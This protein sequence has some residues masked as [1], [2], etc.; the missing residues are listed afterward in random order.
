MVLILS[1]GTTEGFIHEILGI[2]LFAI[3]IIHLYLNKTWFKTLNKG[4]YKTRRIVLLIINMLLLL[5]FILQFISGF[6]ISEYLNHFESKYSFL[7]RDLHLIL[8]GWI[9]LFLGI[10]IAMNKNAITRKRLTYF[11]FLPFAIYG[12]Y[13]LIATNT[14]SYM[15][16][17]SR[18]AFINYENKIKTLFNSFSIIIFFTY[19]STLFDTLMKIRREHKYEQGVS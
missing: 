2:V 5:T 10:H 13:S 15:F 1:I 12:F 14:L 16:F 4:K 11:I 19:F 8:Y 9:C 18:F 3:L 6:L 17:I 7:M